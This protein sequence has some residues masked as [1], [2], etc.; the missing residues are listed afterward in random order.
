M[1]RLGSWD[2]TGYAPTWFDVDNDVNGWW[3][4]D[5]VP[6]PSSPP[7]P[8]PP[9]PTPPQPAPRQT[10][11]RS[12]GYGS[13]YR[14]EYNE[15]W[16]ERRKKREEPREEPYEQEWFREE[17]TEPDPIEKAPANDVEPI[18]PQDDEVDYAILPI[19]ANGLVRAMASGV[20]HYFVDSKAGPSAYVRADDGVRYFYAGVK[21]RLN[22]PEDGDR[23]EA[24]DS[25]GRSVGKTVQSRTELPLL[26]ETIS[27]PKP[28]TETKVAVASLPVAQ[29]AAPITST[30]SEPIVEDR[31][32]KP[33]VKWVVVVLVGAGIATA[34]YLATR[35][36]PKRRLTSGRRRRA[37]LR[38]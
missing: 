15:S 14:F 3:D 24:G 11:P 26:P 35:K 4:R 9:P 34:V 5:L 27:P 30:T 37:R 13:S 16:R 23:V 2:L 7:P 18:P 21:P 38:R 32:L 19:G 10:T 31:Q 1:A 6:G 36:T 28:K 20:V 33:W 12:G 22:G 25:I 29:A 17:V 8:P